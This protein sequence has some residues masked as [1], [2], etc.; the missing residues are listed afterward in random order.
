M[1]IKRLSFP[2]N[3]G[4]PIHTFDMLLMSLLSILL[5]SLLRPKMVSSPLI[6][7]LHRRVS[8]TYLHR[9]IP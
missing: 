1:S 4:F 8:S 2:R 6:S 5:F 3:L 9:V 7:N